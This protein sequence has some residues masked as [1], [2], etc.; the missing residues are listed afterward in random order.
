MPFDIP[1]SW[2]WVRLRTICTK[3]VDGDHNPP[4]GEL[5]ETEY[6]MISSTNVNNDRIENLNKVRFLSREVFEQENLRTQA[7]K[8]DIFFTSVGTLG[9][10]CV[11]NGGYNLTFQRS[12]SVIKTLIFNYYLKYCFDSIYFQ[13]K[14][15]RESTGT[16]QKGFYLNQL[17][18]CMIP[19]PP[20]AEQHRIVAKIEELLS[21]CDNLK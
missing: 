19:I 13:T 17:S 1:E 5:H 14:V 21:L 8:G 20:L 3:L 18:E 12:V 6:L 4:K 10:S 2:E 11:Y 15:K 7:S 16:A 9:R